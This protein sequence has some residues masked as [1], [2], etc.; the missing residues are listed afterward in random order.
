[1]FVWAHANL[2]VDAKLGV[3]RLYPIIQHRIR[4]VGVGVAVEP[5]RV[6]EEEQQQTAIGSSIN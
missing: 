5:S 4:L 6:R 3:E 2:R 1:M